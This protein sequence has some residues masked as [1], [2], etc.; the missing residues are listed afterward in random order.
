LSPEDCKDVPEK[1]KAK[2][3]L[4]AFQ[5]AAE[6]HDLE[7]FKNMLHEHNAAMQAD[8]D[9]KEAREAERAAKADKK[10]RKSEVKAD[11]DVEM[12]DAE[13]APKK[14]SKKRKKEVDSDDEESE[15]VSISL[16]RM[17]CSDS[18]GSL[19][20]PLRQPRSS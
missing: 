13:A 6:G 10:K 19:Q 3:L 5:V 1:G 4:A 18:D 8:W 20:R 9:A 16:A 2:A 11:T 12:E 14:S 17:A 15:K 7:Y